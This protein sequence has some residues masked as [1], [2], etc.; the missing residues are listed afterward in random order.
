MAVSSVTLKPGV[1]AE[2]TPLLN[3]AGISTSSF[4][5]FRAGLVEK[6]GGWE[7]FYP[8]PVGSYVRDMHAWQDLNNIA[9]LAAGAET[10]LSIIT[11]GVKDTITPQTTTTDETA[12]FSTTN[13]STT[14][15]I[16][17]NS[18]TPSTNNSVF[19]STQVSVGGIVLFG[20]YPIATVAGAH[21]YTIVAASA[22]TATVASGGAV[23]S[24]TTT[25][26][27]ALVTV[28]LNDHGKSVG[29]AFPVLVATTVGGLTLSGLYTIR[30]VLTANTFTISA[31][32]TATS[33]TSVSE[34]AGE[35]R[36]V[37][38]ITVTP[39]STGSG[40]GV[41]GYGMGGYGTGTPAATGTGTPITTTDWCL[42]NWGEFLVASPANGPLYTWQPGSGYQTASIIT[43]AP[44]VNTGFFVAMPQRQIV[45]YGSS[46]DGVQDPLLVRWCDVDN[47]FAWLAMSTNQ[48]GAYRIPTGSLLVGGLQGPQQGLLWTDIDLWAMQYTGP[49]YVYS[50]NKLM[51]GCGLK[52]KHAAGQ[53]GNNIFWMGSSS[54]YA[55]AGGGPQVLPCSVWD[56]VF[57]N[58]DHANA[59]KIR[60]GVNSQFDEIAWFFPS[61]TGGT[62]QNDSCVKFNVAEKA[63][64]FTIGTFGRTSWV[65]QSVLGSAI[66]A[67]GSTGIIYQHEQG[68]DADGQPIVAS[69]ETGYFFLTEGA[70][71]VFIDMFW[72]DFK[73]G[74]Y[75]G[76]DTARVQITITTIDFPGGT[77][78]VHG[79]YTVTQATEF[80]N[81]RARGRMAKMTIS[82]ADAGSFWRFG[83]PRF[84]YAQDGRR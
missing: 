8:F 74:V 47:Y 30:S 34:N 76:G 70:V 66:A 29:D 78:V 60:C 40:Y 73:W 1:N 67:D 68:Y 83:R 12:N 53:L 43:Q 75:S 84:R 18:I 10:S 42:D 6:Y 82:S 15:T 36:S 46:Y 77:P 31:A 14:V 79:P 58:L 71:K 69:V 3:E 11:S 20:M 39:V 22:A 63:W 44:V 81:V 16:V 65:D 5:R 37:H 4:V 17:D 23:P 72:P 80:V 32:N 13:G 45:V 28:T 25:S 19:F 50:F 24:F 7:K 55:L 62:G 21:T 2:F 35:V 64:D 33:S 38:Y 41:G 54:F 52:A 9:H 27:S 26:G 57:Q 48:A 49:S 51:S 56:V 61:V 59:S